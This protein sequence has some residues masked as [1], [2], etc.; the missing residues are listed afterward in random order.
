MP[1]SRLEVVCVTGLPARTARPF[2]PPFFAPR[3][4]HAARSS[5]P[6]PLRLSI[7]ARSGLRYCQE[8]LMTKQLDEAPLG[9]R[10]GCLCRDRGQLCAVVEP[11]RRY[12]RL[13]SLRAAQGGALPPILSGKQL[14]GRALPL[15]LAGSLLPAGDQDQQTSSTSFPAGATATARWATPACAVAMR[16]PTSTQCDVCAKEGFFAYQQT[17]LGKTPAQIREAINRREYESIDLDK[18]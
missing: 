11:G 1:P 17:K 6:R 16:P 7:P 13:P 10:I 18:Q 8:S 3:C 5:L 2:V 9:S 12:S 14:T 15:S 4:R